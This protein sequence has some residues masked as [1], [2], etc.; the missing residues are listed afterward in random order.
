V[1]QDDGIGLSPEVDPSSQEKLGLRLVRR[2]AED[3]L[4]GSISF[5]GSDGTRV[6]IRFKQKK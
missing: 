6:V 5:D 3:Q 4:G 1:V 2:I